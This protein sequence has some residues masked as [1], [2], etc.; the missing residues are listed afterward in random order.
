MF[1][2][3]VQEGERMPRTKKPKVDRVPIRI[4]QAIMDEVD[5]LVEKYGLWN[6]QQFVESAIAEKIEKWKAIE[7]KS[8]SSFESHPK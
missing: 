4:L 5:R 3:N 7:A 6:R 8:P 2:N 1:Y